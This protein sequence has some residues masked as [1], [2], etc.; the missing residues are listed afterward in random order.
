VRQ[1]IGLFKLGVN[2]RLPIGDE[3]CIRCRFIDLDGL[4]VDL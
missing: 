2:D 1:A 4:Q 3:A